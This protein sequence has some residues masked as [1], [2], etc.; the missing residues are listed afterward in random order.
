MVLTGGVCVEVAEA[1]GEGGDH[2]A[3]HPALLKVSLHLRP[4]HHLDA[5]AALE[6][7]P[8]VVTLDQTNAPGVFQP[9]P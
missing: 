9:R 1:P 4:V 2:P 7:A 8:G 6:S 3:L 5:A